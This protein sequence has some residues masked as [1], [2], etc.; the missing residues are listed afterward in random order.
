LILVLLRSLFPEHA[1][2][3]I[4]G[5]PR[6]ALRFSWALASCI[7]CTRLGHLDGMGLERLRPVLQGRLLGRA[8]FVGALVGL[9][10]QCLVAHPDG[11]APLGFARLAVRRFAACGCVAL[12]PSQGG[13]TR[14][15]A[16]PRICA[17]LSGLRTASLED[18]GSQGDLA[19]G[20]APPR[21]QA[22][23]RPEARIDGDPPS[24]ECKVKGHTRRRERPS[25][26]YFRAHDT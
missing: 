21:P 4:G 24:L 2:R 5:L 25:G 19:L 10:V 8:G 12:A 13:R 9:G 7:E 11:H 20:G 22:L 18:V 3:P 26:L 23:G 6:G 14:A 15:S 16:A 17:R 1:Q